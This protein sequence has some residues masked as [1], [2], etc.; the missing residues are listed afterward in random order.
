LGGAQ[1]LHTNSLDEALALPGEHAV[2]LALRTQQVLAHETGI[3][4]EADPLGGCYYLE[5]LTADLERESLEL[6][7]EI[8][9]MGGMIPAIEAGYP[10]S[11][12]AQASYEYQQAIER[13]QQII[14]GV[15]RFR[16]EDE[17]PISVLQ[18][19]HRPAELQ[20]EKLE[21]LR[22]NRDS[23]RVQRD[24]DALAVAATGHE[25][26]MPYILDAVRASATVGEICE[27]LRRVFGLYQES[28]VF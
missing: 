14:V 7:G 8:D 26:T 1:S 2:T 24:L 19:D 17:A 21:R 25:N 28:S 18:M 4:A 12:I 11:K 6:I 3:L 22:R 5:R 13:E 27:A 15:N 16:Q 9:A 10:Q 23:S 20:A